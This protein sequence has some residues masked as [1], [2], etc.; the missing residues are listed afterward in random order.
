[1]TFEK[2][3]LQGRKLLHHGDYAAALT[4]AEAA[5]TLDG[6]IFDA[7]TLRG[8]ALFLLARHAEALE[9]F[10]LAFAAL[11]REEDHEPTPTEWA[12]AHELD[13]D[14][15]DRVEVLETLLALREQFAL[16]TPLLSL[17]GEMAEQSGRFELA[18]DTFE[19]LVTEHPD[20][21]NAWEGLVHVTCHDNLDAGWPVVQRAL[22]I[23]PTHPLFHEFFGFLCFRRRQYQQALRAYRQAIALGADDLENQ[24]SLVQCFLALDEP[25]AA[26]DVAEEVV[27]KQPNEPDAYR[28][29]LDV[30]LQC[31]NPDHALRF[32]HQL[33]RLEPTH[34]DTYLDKARVELAL[35]DWP[36]AERTLALGARKAIDGQWALFDLVDTLITEGK[37]E[38]ALRVAQLTAGLA[39]DHPESY[40]AQGKVYREQGEFDAALTAFQ[41]AARLAPREDAY[42]TWIGVVLDNMGEYQPALHVFTTVLTRH[43]ADIWTLSNRGLTYLALKTPQSAL[44]D[45]THAIELDP[46][47]ASLFFW[48]GCAY[49]QLEEPERALEDLRRAIAL[50]EEM[51]EWLD[52]EAML[53]PLRHHPHF[54]LLRDPDLFRDGRED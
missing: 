25:E 36:A 23:H 38:L 21:L 12:G 8:R 5:L 41:Q 18:R 9:T 17:L 40:A 33:V 6:E 30:A 52:E 24:S 35:D 31:D 42:Q 53:D 32:A 51:L 34:S 29:A 39:P 26:L 14:G 50:D 37:L 16:D 44:D 10:R 22:K 49:V 7:L 19:A 20:N 43:P 4:Q 11:H 1:M 13:T 27:R 3:L 48:R 46:E 2:H 15:D 47:D 28:F 45:L 54:R